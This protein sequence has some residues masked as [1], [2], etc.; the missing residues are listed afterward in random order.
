MNL[1]NFL[2]CSSS[3]V[4]NTVGEVTTMKDFEQNTECCKFIDT[5]V[6]T[7]SF[8]CSKIKT[9]NYLNIDVFINSSHGLDSNTYN[10]FIIKIYNTNKD[11]IILCSIT[12]I[13]KL[14][15]DNLSDKNLHINKSRI[16]ELLK[17]SLFQY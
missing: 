9:H 3:S 12:H 16:N 15:V 11:N 2:E 17:L 14:E 4:L 1:R 6:Q 13:L 10:D 7:Y 5:I 8:T